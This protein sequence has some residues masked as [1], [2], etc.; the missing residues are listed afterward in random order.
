MSNFSRRELL[1]FFGV[2]AATA[3][4]SDAFGNRFFSGFNSASAQAVP[5]T[6]TPVRTPHAL[7]IFRVQNSFL[8]SGLN[9][10]GT[11]IP[12]SS[13]AGRID[14]FT[15]IDDV[16]VPPEFIRYTILSWGDRLF[17]NNDEY[18]GYNNDYTGYVPINGNNE[19]W[20]W[21][22]HEYVSY[23]FSPLVP[24]APAGTGALPDTFRPVIGFDLPRPTNTTL[25]GSA[26]LA[27]LSATE[28]RLFLGEC[29]YNLGGSIVRIT[30]T[31]GQY[32]PSSTRAG[33]RRLHGL[34]G[35]GINADRTDTYRTVTS[36]GTRSYQNGDRNFL[37]GTGPAAQDVFVNV[38]TDG[39]GNRI[40]GTGYSCSGG[41][42]P[43]GTVLSCEENF[44]GSTAFFIGVTEGVNANGSQTGY[45][46]GFAGTEFGLVGEKYGWAVEVDL[47]D[48]SVTPRKHTA[49][50]RFRHENVAVRAESG[51]KLVVYQGDDRRGGHT[52]KY[53]STNN[54]SN[55]T[56]KSNSR[57]FEAGIL[58]AAKYNVDGTGRW[59]PL[60]LSTPTDPIRP[61][62]ISSVA[63]ANG[64]TTGALSLG[65]S[66][67]PRRNG[68]A[69]S[70]TSG[71]FF[72]VERGDTE[73]AAF[74]SG[75]SGYLG[76]TLADFYTSQ[77][78]ILVDAYP[79]AN[80]AGAT[81]T[82][83]PEDLEINPRNL[84]EVFIAYTDGAPGG[85][86]Y[87]DSRIF[88]VAKFGAEATAQ[89]SNGGLYKITEDSEDGTGL[90]FRWERLLQGGEAG[91]DQGGGFANVDNLVFDEQN[92]IYG[93]IDMTLSSINGFVNG[94]DPV[95]N[96][97]DHS[98]TGNTLPDNLRAVYGNNWMFYIPVSGVNAGQV[99]PLAIGPVRCE[100]TGPTFVGDTLFL[101]VQHPGEGDPIGAGRIL[102]RQIEML[103][104]AGNLFNQNR[105]VPLGSNFPSNIGGTSATSPR[106]C[107]IGIRRRNSNNSNSFLG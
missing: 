35:L 4:A 12:P 40:I 74:V 41:N 82:A 91:S 55:P 104:L 73:N 60:L 80:L 68:V 51:R 13:N 72:T 45:G 70:T 56:D 79:A 31:N 100:M 97:I 15:C 39:L 77:G 23:P 87:P 28:R 90:T 58:Y 6:F 5:T 43:W 29:Y 2:S 33:N 3:V 24:E 84:R 54:V 50:G 71:G 78:A 61:S 8:A 48:A 49:L 1:T 95:Q 7:P 16:V 86:G 94:P 88:Q 81:P 38:N 27:A 98:S 17:P 9:G 19:G 14:S 53:V 42:T 92:N 65:R 64:Q 46:A 63:F 20:L 52:W 18:V 59:V 89:Q 25:T 106:P 102:N 85:D 105:N 93:V 47:A 26:G 107:V 30:K 101:S 21:V 69:G 10:Q 36:W 22:N 62:D 32:A 67:L 44:Q 57:L 76:R 66:N 96:V 83:R 99:V 103:D 11:V 34:S 75:A 37:I